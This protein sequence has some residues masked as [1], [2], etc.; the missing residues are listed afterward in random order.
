MKVNLPTLLIL[1]R[2]LIS[3]DKRNRKK[4]PKTLD[5]KY[6]KD[7]SYY[8][9]SNKQQ[10]FDIYYAKKENRKNI[11]LIEIHG[12]SYIFGNRIN[13]YPFAI[14]FLKE[15]I[16]VITLD[17]LPNDGKRDTFD[18]IKDCFY[19]VKYIIEHKKELDIENHK[20]FITGDSAGGHLA[21]FLSE[22]LSIDYLRDTLNLPTIDIDIKGTLLNCP[23]YD[24]ENCGI[25]AMTNLAMKRMFG[26]RY[27]DREWFKI[28]SP[29]EYIKD[30]TKPI[31]VSTCTNDFLR[32]ESLSLKEDCK[33]RNNFTFIDIESKDKKVGHVHNVNVINLKESVIVNTKMNEFINK[34]C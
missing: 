9:N 27:K 24:F 10:M 13:S 18:L 26:P 20:I 19:G 6:I 25:G 2:Y 28:L 34:Y 22:I 32:N 31:F 3:Y 21:L 17:Y 14:E 15:G 23:V 4:D 33:E 29:K 7:I 12:G 16:D 11:L 1:R 5:Y 8:D 30:Y